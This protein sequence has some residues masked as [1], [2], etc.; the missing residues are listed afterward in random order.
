[1]MS[2][3]PKRANVATQLLQRNFPKIAAQLLWDLEGWGLGLA[4]RDFPF[5][6]NALNQ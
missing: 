5:E 1:M 6:I 2:A 4:E 3:L